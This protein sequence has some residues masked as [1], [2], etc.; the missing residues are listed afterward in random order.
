VLSLGGAAVIALIWIAVRAFR[1]DVGPVA[2][3]I[4]IGAAGIL[5]WGVQLGN[6]AETVWT[7]VTPTLNDVGGGGAVG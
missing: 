7:S 2:L 1:H 3:V 5:G 6:G 4:A